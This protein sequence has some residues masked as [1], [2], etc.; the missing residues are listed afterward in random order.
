MYFER[1][2]YPTNEGLSSN[3][4]PTNRNDSGFTFEIVAFYGGLW[5]VTPILKLYGEKGLIWL[6]TH[7]F[8]AGENLHESAIL[9]Q[10]KA[11][12]ELADE[13]ENTVH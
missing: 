4:F 7:Q 11:L 6:V 2:M 5:L 8:E 3:A 12:K 13:N 9:Y 1:V 10:E